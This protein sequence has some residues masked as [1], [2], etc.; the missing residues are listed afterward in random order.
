VYPQLLIG[1]RKQPYIDEQWLDQNS[2][3]LK[4]KEHDIMLGGGF[5]IPV[6]FCLVDDG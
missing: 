5:I 6:T 3:L 1:R 4:C 2:F